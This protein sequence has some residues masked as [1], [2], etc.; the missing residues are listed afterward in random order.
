MFIHCRFDGNAAFDIQFVPSEVSTRDYFH[1][2]L[3]GQ[4]LAAAV[5]W[6]ATFDF[7]DQVAPEST[8]TEDAGVVTIT[9]TDNVGVSGIEY[10][11]DGGAYQRYTGPFAAA[12]GTAVTYRAVDVNGNSEATKT[13]TA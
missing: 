4:A 5:T 2:S 7:T 6:R 11:L 10:S 9:A 1:P 8:A 13:L 3:S 12:P